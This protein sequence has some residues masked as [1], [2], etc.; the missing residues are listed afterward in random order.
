VRIPYSIVARK[1]KGKRTLG[2]PKYRWDDII[3][4]DVNRNILR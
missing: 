3:K 2:R 1:T 4:I